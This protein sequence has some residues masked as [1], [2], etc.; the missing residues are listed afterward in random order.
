MCT[1]PAISPKVGKVR[2][3]QDY[4]FLNSLSLHGTGNCAPG[5]RLRPH[6]Q[7]RCRPVVERPA[8]SLGR[9]ASATNRVRLIPLRGS[10]F[11]H[12]RF[13]RLTSRPARSRREKH[14]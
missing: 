10:G 9:I 11:R 4:A 12:S 2:D 3:I 14:N 7:T 6:R 13:H 5:A 1:L 8:S